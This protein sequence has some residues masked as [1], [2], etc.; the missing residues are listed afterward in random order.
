MRYAVE[1]IAVL[2]MV[3]AVGGIFYGVFKGTISLSVRT[4]QFL[5]I[6]FVVP[7]IIIMSMEHVMSSDSSSAL[8]GIILGYVLAGITRSE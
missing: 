4:I 1:I 5:A 3:G 6:S 7:A 2:I 8:I